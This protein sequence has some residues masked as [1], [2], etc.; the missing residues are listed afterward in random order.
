MILSIQNKEQPYSAKHTHN[1]FSF[2]L[3]LSLS[4]PLPPSQFLDVK[5]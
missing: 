3:P 4:P 5:I 2:I 1:P